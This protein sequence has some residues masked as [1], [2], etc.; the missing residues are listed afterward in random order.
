MI[1]DLKLNGLSNVS[2]YDYPFDIERIAP[3]DGIKQICDVVL[4]S[5]NSGEQ[6]SDMKAALTALTVLISHATEQGIPFGSII[7]AISTE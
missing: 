6:R 4:S 5:T 1:E 3:L 2:V 7:E